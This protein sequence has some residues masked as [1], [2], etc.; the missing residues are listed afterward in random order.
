MLSFLM[1]WLLN[2]FFLIPTYVIRPHILIFIIFNTLVMIQTFNFA[3]ILFFS[4]LFAL[5]SDPSL[6]PHFFSQ[7]LPLTTSNSFL[8]REGEA[9]HGH[10]FTLAYQ[11]AV[12][13]DIFS[14]FEARPGTPVR[15]KGSKGRQESQ[16]Q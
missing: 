5:H 16:R 15:E 13:I 14:H 10:Q 9:S 7:F 6:S 8:Q 12:V 11:V 1:P 2:D 3:H 4:N